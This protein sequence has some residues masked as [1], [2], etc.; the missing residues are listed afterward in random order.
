MNLFILEGNLVRE[1]E[2]KLVGQRTVI[3]FSIAENQ[4]VKDA[5][6]NWVDG[7]PS[8]YDMNFWTDK[9]DYWL[10][11]LGKGTSVVCS[12]TLKQDRWQDK[13]TGKT[14]SKINFTVTEI[15]AKWLPEINGN[16]ALQSAP[17]PEINGTAAPQSAPASQT[18]SSTATNA[19]DLPF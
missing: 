14:S 16:A 10:K 3:K 11:R 5:N 1:P 18:Q 2:T 13:E 17:A 7:E 9:P 12:G 6:G 4:R 8:Y 19:E 15:K